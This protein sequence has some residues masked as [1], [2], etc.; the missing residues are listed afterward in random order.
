MRDAASAAEEEA[1][2]PESEPASAPA[3]QPAADPP[4]PPRD[5]YERVTARL[6]RVERLA[7]EAAQVGNLTAAQRFSKQ[8]VDLDL[9]VA[10]LDKDR[11][12]DTDT[13]TFTRAQIEQARRDITERVRALAEDLARTGGLSCAHCGREIRI[14][15]A[16]GE[17]E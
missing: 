3:P 12:S 2:A 9:L 6:Q 8:A 17:R 10:R 13:V 5:T 4:A 11:K 16:R 15:L 1:P 14:A 7:E